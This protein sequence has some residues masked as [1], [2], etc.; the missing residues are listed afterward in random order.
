MNSLKAII[1]I[2]ARL[3]SSRLPNKVLADIHG[4]P[5]LWHVY[6]RCL[7]ANKAS[8]VHIATDSEQVATLV[9]AWGGQAWMTPNDCVSGTERIVSILDKLQ[10]DIIV[11]VQGDQPLIDPIVINQL[12]EVFER[13]NPLP[14]IVTPACPILDH[15]FADPNVVKMVLRHDGYVLYFSRHPIPYIRDEKLENWSTVTTFLGHVGI[16]GYRRSVLEEYS[17]LPRSPLEELEKLE[18]LRFLQA[19]KSIFAFQ[20]PHEHLS[21]DTATDLEQIRIKLSEP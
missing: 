19:G 21:V 14:D 2:P 5:M 20:T 15:R 11:N 3:A 1:V 13:Q 17:S 16:Y 8:E 4:H 10:A 12:I 9:R 7:Q 18:Q 6:Q